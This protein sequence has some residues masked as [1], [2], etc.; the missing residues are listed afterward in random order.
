MNKIENCI[1]SI[2]EPV[3]N[4]FLLSDYIWVSTPNNTNSNIWENLNPTQTSQEQNKESMYYIA[5][6]RQ[7]YKKATDICK[8]AIYDILK[9]KID[10]WASIYNEFDKNLSNSPE[11]FEW[12]NK[13]EIVYDRMYRD[14]ERMINNIHLPQKTPEVI[15]L[16][17][18]LLN[19]CTQKIFQE[20]KEMIEKTQSLKNNLRT[21]WFYS[22]DTPK[23]EKWRERLEIQQKLKYDFLIKNNEISNAIDLCYDVL[24]WE[25]IKE[26]ENS[27]DEVTIINIPN[28]SFKAKIW[29]ERL[30]FLQEQKN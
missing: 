12:L 21:K 11:I 14:L 9:P 16:Y 17:N 27:D 24:N 22:V 23:A 10:N 28:S 2:Q 3:Q 29:S 30:N 18:K 19:L 4:H 20:V 8:K 6:Q 1:S 7:D 15:E 26:H 5:L 13:E 25:I